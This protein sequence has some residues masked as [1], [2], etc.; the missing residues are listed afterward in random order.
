MKTIRCTFA[1]G[2]FLAAFAA[3]AGEMTMMSFNVR[4]GCG[5]HDPF[6]LPEGGLGHLPQCAE[7]IRSADPDW[8]AIQEID[9]CSQRVG[10]VD[11]TAALADFMRLPL[12]AEE[13]D[14]IVYKNAGRLLGIGG[15]RETT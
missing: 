10:L 1:A 4:I 3:V 12:T 13:K 11:Q 2:L 6:K 7:V 9:R 14:S 5:M 8:V 15:N